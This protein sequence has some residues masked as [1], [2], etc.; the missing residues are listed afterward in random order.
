VAFGYF[1]DT[2]PSLLAIPGYEIL[3]EISNFRRRKKHVFLKLRR[4]EEDLL[5]SSLDIMSATG[6][7]Y[8]P[9]TA[10]LLVWTAR[11]LICLITA[12]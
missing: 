2:D 3:Q 5:V 12:I 1:S 8:F 7:L 9:Q 4:E 11:Q 6:V 10:R